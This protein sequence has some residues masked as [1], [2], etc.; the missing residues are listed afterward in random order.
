MITTNNTS[1]QTDEPDYPTVVTDDD[2]KIKWISDSS[3]SSSPTTSDDESAAS[4][5]EANIDKIQKRTKP[6]TK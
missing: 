6:N 3:F 1:T 4:V 2:L 5:T